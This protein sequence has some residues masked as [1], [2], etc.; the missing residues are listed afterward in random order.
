[1]FE[2]FPLLRLRSA[3][4]CRRLARQDPA[5]TQVE[6]LLRLVRTARGTAFGRA[7]RFAEIRSVA[8]YQSAVPLRRHEDF[9]QR[10]W[11]PNFPYAQNAT[12]TGLI[13]YL[14]KLPG[15]G[16]KF[17]PVS[18][19]M[20]L[21]GHAAA[22]DLLA[23]HVT[24]HPASRLTG[25]LCLLL[26]GCTSLRRMGPGVRSGEASGI[27]GATM[28]GWLRSRAW[29][30]RDISG[31][32]D[33]DERLDHIAASAAGRDIR[34]MAGAPDRLLALFERLSAR[35]K[36]HPRS[37]APLFPRLELIVHTGLLASHQAVL[38]G[39]LEGTAASC[40][41]IHA[42][43]EGFI[44]AADRGPGEGLRLM[45]DHGLFVEFIPPEDLGKPRPRRFWTGNAQPG[46]DYALA[47][48]SN[49]GLWSMITDT[50]VRLLSL[51]PPRIRVVPSL[52]LAR[53][54]G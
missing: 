24:A 50:S 39:W 14:A 42:A 45:L 1:M 53:P 46:R 37:L 30:P 19:A 36:D 31:V 17:L 23:F 51:E 18:R 13:P 8:E 7:H 25:G 27:A 32:A 33:E 44:A 15:P 5:R 40:R 10:W 20:I 34:V 35:H 11:Q 22:L 6:T 49:A 52:V 16:A 29:P 26:G 48:T 54:A 28:P 43:P 38:D 21:A 41:E 9:A 4:R 2:T 3:L 12:W 47:L